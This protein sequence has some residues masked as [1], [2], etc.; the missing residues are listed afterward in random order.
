MRG[1]RHEAALWARAIDLV[2]AHSIESE[3]D[4]GPLF[5]RPPADADAEV[6]KRLRQMYEAG[7]WVLVE[8]AIADLPA[9]L[10]WL[11]ES[12][13]VTIEQLAAIQHALGVTSAADLWAVVNEQRLHALPGVEPGVEAAIA[14]ALP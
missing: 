8:S 4:A 6:L 5:E 14:A 11:F 9:D 12:G 10:R 3:D 1:D 13:A 2:R 7:G